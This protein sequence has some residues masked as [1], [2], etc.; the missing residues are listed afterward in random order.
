[1]LEC[2]KHHLYEAS[3]GACPVCNGNQ[4]ANIPVVQVNAMSYQDSE[5]PTEFPHKAAPQ[6]PLARAFLVSSLDNCRYNLFSGD[7]RIGRKA[8][9]NDVTLSHPTVGR[10]HIL[11]REQNGHYTLYDRGSSSGTFV[12]GKRLRGSIL[13]ENGDQ[14]TLGEVSL[15]FMLP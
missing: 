7:T 6:R 8:S 13:L 10:E 5:D 14:I 9:V 15:K 2:E 3:L 12:N 11:I 1:M 4:A